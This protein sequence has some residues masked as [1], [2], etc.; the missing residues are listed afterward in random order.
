MEDAE[1]AQLA[2]DRSASL[3]PSQYRTSAAV[4][5][6]LA[7]DRPDP[8]ATGAPGAQRPYHLPPRPRNR[9]IFSREP[10]PPSPLSGTHL[11]TRRRSPLAS[12]RLVTVHDPFAVAVNGNRRSA[13][14]T[15]TARDFA[16]I[17][18]CP[19]MELPE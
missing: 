5:A 3:Q 1:F 4:V 9:L 18:A 6:P 16:A 13:L 8:A 19:S 10:P 17:P 12:D 15:A 7:V 11:Q 14:F 2:V